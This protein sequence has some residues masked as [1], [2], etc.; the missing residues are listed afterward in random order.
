MGR[1]QRMK[2][3]G[4]NNWTFEK[5]IKDNKR[6]KEK[7]LQ[8]QRNKNNPMGLEHVAFILL[9]RK[10]GDY[11]QKESPDSKACGVDGSKARNG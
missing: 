3:E 10:P 4:N 11:R 2:W 5:N 7:I 1:C 8:E 6:N 9:H